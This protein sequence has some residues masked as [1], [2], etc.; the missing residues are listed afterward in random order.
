MVFTFPSPYEGFDL[1]TR[2]ERNAHRGKQNQN[3]LR[4]QRQQRLFIYVCLSG[5]DKDLGDFVAAV[6]NFASVMIRLNF[7][8][9]AGL[10]VASAES[11]VANGI[12]TILQM[13]GVIQGST[14]RKLGEIKQAVRAVSK[15][16]I[17]FQTIDSWET[18]WSSIGKISNKGRCHIAVCG[19]WKLCRNLCGQVTDHFV[20]L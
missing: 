6:G 2:T 5:M 13:T 17:T 14:D 7:P 20:R 10:Q 1:G 18:G 12:F 8:L 16:L 4:H 19:F 15:R 11:N 9:L 3:L